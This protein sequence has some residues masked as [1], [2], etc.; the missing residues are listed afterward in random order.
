M[1]ARTCGFEIDP[2][3]PATGLDKDKVER[4]V[5]TLRSAFGKVLRRGACSLEELGR[6]SDERPTA[7]MD[8]LTCPVTGT[9]V[10]TPF[11]V[12][13][14]RRLKPGLPDL[15]RE[16]TLQHAVR[17][18]G[19]H[20][21]VWVTL[22]HVVVRGAGQEF[23]RYARGTEARLLIDPEHYERPSTQEV[24]RDAAGTEVRCWRRRFVE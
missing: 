3:R 2:C 11:D 8:R 12:V 18:V 24:E 16:Q 10:A 13:V 20:V 22:R 14:T 23:G 7:L 5:R 19:R 4:G 6:L 1:S 21:D 17:R 9:T 15:V